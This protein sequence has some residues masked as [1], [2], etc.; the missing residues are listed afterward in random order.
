MRGAEGPVVY[1][2]LGSQTPAG[3]TIVFPKQPSL[4]GGNPWICLAF[5]TG[6]GDPILDKFLL[7]RCV[8]DF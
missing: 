3:E 8:Q 7:G 1:E 6:N 5:L 2:G 4:G